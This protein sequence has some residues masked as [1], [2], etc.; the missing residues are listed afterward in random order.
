MTQS[1]AY[2]DKVMRPEI[3]DEYHEQMYSLYGDDPVFRRR[4]NETRPRFLEL[5]QQVREIMMRP[6]MGPTELVVRE[7]YEDNMSRRYM[8][9]RSQVELFHPDIIPLEFVGHFERIGNDRQV[10]I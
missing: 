5:L 8:H 10:I 2:V 4:A 1:S 3:L 6:R 9:W 7:A